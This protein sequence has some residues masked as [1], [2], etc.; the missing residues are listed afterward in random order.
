MLLNYEDLSPVRK[1]VEVEIPADLLTN[2][3]KRV[4]T[5]FGRQAK[6]PGFRPGKV[7]PSVVRNRFAK[8]IQDEV[9]N[10]LLARTFAEAGREKGVQP[11]GE[12]RRQ[13]IGPYIQGGAGK[14]K[15]GVQGTA[16]VQ[17]A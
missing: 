11:V 5:E 14:Q 4:T 17:R 10:R 2:E 15:G 1:T 12:P 3:A 13:P 6:I 9:L 8:D 16:S 7:P